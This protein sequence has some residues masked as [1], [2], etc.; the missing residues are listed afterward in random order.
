[1]NP[2]VKYGEYLKSGYKCQVCN[3]PHDLNAHHRTYENRGN[4]L[5][6]LDDLVCLCRRCHEIFHGK[7]PV[8]IVP[9]TQNLISPKKKPKKGAI[10]HP[11]WYNHEAD[12]PAGESIELTKELVDRTR[13]RAAA[14]TNA[15]LRNLGISKP[16][17]AGWPTALVGKIISR[18][19]YRLALEGRSLFRTGP[20][21]G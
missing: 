5:K 16:L 12:M 13:T 15:T 4:E 21:S 9:P 17:M 3:S 6:H 1:M 19:S 2:V 14:F 20:L 18:E 7:Q 11:E 10:I 8:V